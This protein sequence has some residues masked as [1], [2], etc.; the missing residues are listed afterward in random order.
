MLEA[1][2][3]G[4]L[5]HS[6]SRDQI[7]AVALDLQAAYDSVWKNGLL[8]KLQQ[9]KIPSYLIHWLRDFLL[10][11]RSLLQ[12]GTNVVECLPECGLPQGS[13]L[14]PTLFLVYIDDLL[15][16]LT[17]LGVTCQAFA[18]DVILWTRGDFRSGQPDPLLSTALL[19]VDQWAEKWMMTFNPTKCEAIC[20]RGS[21]DPSTEHVPSSFEERANSH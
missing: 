21:S 5:G 13:P 20:F 6:R 3:G 2:R 1:G 10:R 16:E 9:K 19:H 17:G 7:Q 11:W 12:V 4:Y 18:D 14:S 8:A 15:D